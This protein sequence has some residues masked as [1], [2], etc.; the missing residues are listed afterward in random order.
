MCAFPLIALLKI[1]QRNQIFYNM[2]IHKIPGIFI[3]SYTFL[4]Y[5]ISKILPKNDISQN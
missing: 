1:L 4:C 3:D 5:S 2:H